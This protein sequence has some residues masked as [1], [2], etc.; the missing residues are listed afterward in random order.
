MLLFAVIPEQFCK[1]AQQTKGGRCSMSL[2]L[3]LYINK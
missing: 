3:F 1:E 2:P